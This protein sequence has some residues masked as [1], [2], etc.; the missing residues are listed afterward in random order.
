MSEY[1]N[2]PELNTLANAIADRG[3]TEADAVTGFSEFGLN[4]TGSNHFIS[5]STVVNVGDYAFHTYAGHTPTADARIWVDLSA[6]PFSL[7]DGIFYRISIDARHI[8]A[9]GDWKI[10]VGDDNLLS[11]DEEIIKTLDSG[12]TQYATYDLD[13]T[14]SAST[15]YLV[16]REFSATNDGG[17]YADNLIVAKRILKGQKFVVDGD[18]GDDVRVALNDSISEL[19]TIDTLHIPMWRLSN[20]M[21]AIQRVPAFFKRID[22]DNPSSPASMLD[23]FVMAVA[24][25]IHTE[26]ETLENFF[27][28][29]NLIHSD[30]V[31]G[32]AMQGDISVDFYDTK[33]EAIGE[34]IDGFPG[35]AFF[36]EAC[37]T[38]NIDPL[39]AV[40]NHDQNDDNGQSV[41]IQLSKAEQREHI[42]DAGLDNVDDVVF[43]E[44]HAGSCY[45]YKDYLGGGDYKIRFIMLDQYDRPDTIVADEYVYGVVKNYSQEQLTWFAET[46][47]ALPDEDYHVVLFM[48]T[49]PTRSTANNNGYIAIQQIVDAFT[50]QGTYNA[51]SGAGDFAYSLNLD[52]SVINGFDGIFVSFCSG[53]VHIPVVAEITINT[54]D[55]NNIQFP[56]IDAQSIG[57][58]RIEFTGTREMATFLVVDV[59]D[60]TIFLLRYG[61]PCDVD[62]VGLPFGDFGI[63]TPITY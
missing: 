19:F 30:I 26:Y 36:E 34:G 13:F 59:I 60:K 8:S 55:Y 24:T 7:T 3:G 46:A 23:R 4:G 1:F 5:Q 2:G 40:G 32:C 61:N 41:L 33:A 39:P 29:V 21:S 17:L 38:L 52:Y 54:R 27:E 57:Y 43:N 9:G 11:G 51:S 16:L 56:S 48:H 14:H 63:D 18:D 6:A 50:Q 42:I 44:S 28:F 10:A 37:D 47:L 49:N 53:H 31:V 25:D 58:S 22:P 12:D 20:I 62:G 15:R 35:L 45:Y